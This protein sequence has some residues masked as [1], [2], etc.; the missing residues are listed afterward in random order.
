MKRFLPCLY[1]A[2]ITASVAAQDRES[3]LQQRIATLELELAA[4]R[5]E[6]A[7]RQRKEPSAAAGAKAETPRI[8]TEETDD[9]FLRVGDFTFGGAMRVNW[10]LGDYTTGATGPSRGGHGGD[11]SLDTFRIDAGYERGPW[12]GNAEYRWYPGTNFFHTLDAGYAMGETHQLRGGLTRVPFGV[13]PYGPSNNWFFDQHYYVGLA[14]DMD[15]GL[16][17]TTKHGDWTVDLAVFGA[18]EPNMRGA[19]DAGARYSF[20]IVDARNDTRYFGNKTPT[21]YEESGQLNLRAIRAFP[22]LAAPTDLGV[23]LQYGHF[24]GNGTRDARPYAASL[25]SLSEY[26]AWTLKL[27][28]THYDY[29]TTTDYVTGGFY[30]YTTDIASRGDILSAALSYTWEKPATWLD[31]ITFYNDFSVIRKPASGYNDS[32]LNVLGAAFAKGG[33]YIYADWALSNGNE[34]VGDFRP[35]M[36][37]D[38]RNRRWQSRWNINL[39]YYF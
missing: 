19:S 12:S 22:D 6:L 5:A 20:D 31:S 17:Y 10:T 39:G 23:S 26:D 21:G 9:A 8:E 34:F 1:L 29:D 38:N 16:V 36:Q 24:N 11:V 30:D 25:H 37:A 18:A 15:L 27:Q 33:W 14:D 3:E 13:G 35:D 28:A 4:A 2:P 32:A 7:D